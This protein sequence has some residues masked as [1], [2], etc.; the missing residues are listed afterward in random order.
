M[1]L[2]KFKLQLGSNF[3]RIQLMRVLLSCWLPCIK[4]KVKLLCQ[5]I[6]IFSPMCYSLQ[7]FENYTCLAHF[8]AQQHCTATLHS[9]VAQQHSWFLLFCHQCPIWYE[10]EMGVFCTTRG[11]L[12]LWDSRDMVPAYKNNFYYKVYLKKC[13]LKTLKQRHPQGLKMKT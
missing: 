8:Y 5:C 10:Q 6:P 11:N 12:S 9:N 1:S 3:Q 4:Q 7:N 2:L 13:W